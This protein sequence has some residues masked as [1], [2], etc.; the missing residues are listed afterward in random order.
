MDIK[1][2]IKELQKLPQDLPIRSLDGFADDDQ[3]NQWVYKVEVTL[4]EETDGKYGE[5]R[6][7]TSE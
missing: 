1:D 2:L 4:H 7:L 3:P 5:V 6:L